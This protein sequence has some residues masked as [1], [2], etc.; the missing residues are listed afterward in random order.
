MSVLVVSRGRVAA[1]LRHRVVVGIADGAHRG[2]ESRFWVA[3][4]MIPPI[5]FAG[6]VRLCLSHSEINAAVRANSL[7]GMLL[8]ARPAPARAFVV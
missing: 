8:S 3:L 4:A 1:T 6:I 5:A 2:R 7:R